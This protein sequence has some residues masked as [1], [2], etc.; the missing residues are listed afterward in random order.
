M[1]A[2]C[3]SGMACHSTRSTFTTLPPASPEGGSDRGLYLSNF[4]YTALSPGFHSSFAN[5]NGPLPVKSVI[6]WSGL[7]SATRFG[8][9]N[10]T[11][12]DGLPRPSST[13][14]V[15]DDST[16]RNVLASTASKPLTKDIIFW[17]VASF[18]PQRLIDAMQSSDVTGLP[19]CHRRPSRSVSVYTRPSALTVYLSTICGCTLPLA[20]VANSVS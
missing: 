12:D 5:T 1:I 16:M 19:S 20:S 7:V 3:W 9:M 11:S 10:G 14:P 13:R 8:I 18:A 17:P 4:T 2:V 15:G 6:C